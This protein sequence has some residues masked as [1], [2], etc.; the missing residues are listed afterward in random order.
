[1]AAQLADFQPEGRR[2]DVAVD[3]PPYGRMLS[4][5]RGIRLMVLRVDAK[6]NYNDHNPGRAPGT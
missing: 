5:I 2:A 1:L 3:D 6:F 4:G